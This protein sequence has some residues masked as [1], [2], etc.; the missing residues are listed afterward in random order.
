MKHFLSLAIF[1]AFTALAAGSGDSG[2][3]A[4]RPDASSQYNNSSPTENRRPSDEVTPELKMA[5]AKQ[6][7]ASG[8]WCPRVETFRLDPFE[9]T[10]NKKVF[11]VMCDDGNN[12]QLYEIITDREFRVGLVREK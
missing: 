10:M 1:V 9:S 4:K 8:Y 6:I 7:E 12:A 11:H 5:T 2:E 3:D